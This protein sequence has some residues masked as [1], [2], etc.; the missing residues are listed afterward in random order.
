MRERVKLAVWSC[1][2]VL[3]ATNV[4][5]QVGHA[6]AQSPYVDLDY[7][8]ELT[9]MGGYVRT[10]HD[11]A[12]VAPKDFSTLGLRYEVTVAGPLALSMDVVSGQ[13]TRDVIDPNKPAATR[14]VGTQSNTEF[15][16]DFA[17]AMNLT[18]KRSW[19][20]L[21][22]QLRVGLGL[23]KNAAA[24]DSSGFNVGTSFAFSWGG[25]VKYVRPGSRLQLRAD[26]T[27]RL[28]KLN[29]PDSYYR[30]ASDGTS[31]LTGTTAKSFYTH[32]TFLTLGVSYLFA[33]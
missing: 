18:G 27:D 29:Y 22:P 2:F 14:K 32:H 25:G 15:A 8:Q 20:S 31:P 19:H 5:A 23:L 28:F 1:L 4:R 21:V 30:F 10:R 11:P 7:N 16:V 13:T 12:G 9:L 3:A 24:D 17:G 33:R 26:V 6:P